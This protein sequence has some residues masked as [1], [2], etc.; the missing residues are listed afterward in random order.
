MEAHKAKKT[1]LSEL[2]ESVGGDMTS[3]IARLEDTETVELFVLEF[4]N[5]PSYHTLLQSL[6]EDDL[7]SAFRAAHTLKGVGYTLGFAR[8]GDC[9][10]ALCEKLRGDIKPSATDLRQLKAEYD[11]VLSA[12]QKYKMSN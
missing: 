9:A 2:Y 6:R 1:S 7:E 11:R 4:A 8:L 5:D 12:I 3:V 10:A